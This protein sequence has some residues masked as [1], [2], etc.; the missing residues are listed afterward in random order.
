LYFLGRDRKQIRIHNNTG[1]CVT[2]QDLERDCGSD[3]PAGGAIVPA[4]GRLSLQPFGSEDAGRRTSCSRP[5]H[6]RGSVCSRNGIDQLVDREHATDTDTYVSGDPTV[7]I[8][9]LYAYFSYA[10]IPYHQYGTVFQIRFRIPSDPKLFSQARSGS[11]ISML[12]LFDNKS[13]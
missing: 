4:S 1:Y 12:V 10:K 8:Y 11:G 5:P 9:L 6:L 7:G 3:E 2:C 13:V